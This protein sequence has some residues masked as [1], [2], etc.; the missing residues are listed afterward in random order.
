MPSRAAGWI[1]IAVSAISFGLLGVLVKIGLARGADTFSMLAFRFAFGAAIL[2]P[3]ALYR[4]RPFPAGKTLGLILLYG[5]CGYFA[6]SLCF[7]IALEHASAGL[8]SLLLYLYPALVALGG[9]AFF[10]ER[11]GRGRLAALAVALIGTGLAVAPGPG[12]RPLGI[13][14][15]LACA[16]IYASYILACSRVSRGEDP[17]N[18]ATLVVGGAAVVYGAI[19]LVRQSP[20]PPSPAAWAAVAGIGIFSTAVAIGAFFAA[21][22]RI[23]PTAAA[24]GSTLEP[25]FTVVLSAVVL[26]EGLSPIQLAG[27]ALI[28]GAVLWLAT[29][30]PASSP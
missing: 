20:L 16:F 27:G 29:R 23:G 17:L 5:A 14:M 12:N 22:E 24:V 26:G 30:P 21:M 11:L 19:A 15:A 28:L 9:A 1:L 13:A 7:F 10:G 4:R 25:V 8:T 2:V 18:V 3:V 6:H